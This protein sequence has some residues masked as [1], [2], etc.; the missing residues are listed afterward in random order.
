LRL[1]DSRAINRD[2]LPRIIAADRATNVPI[3]SHSM[4]TVAISINGSPI[5]VRSA[6]NTMSQDL[7][8][9]HMYQVDDGSI[10]SHM[11]G[12]GAVALAI[13]LLKLVKEPGVTP[14]VA[15]RKPMRK[16]T[17]GRGRPIK[18]SSAG[19]TQPGGLRETQ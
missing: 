2:N 8:G 19:R 10:V 18:L 5:I 14:P 16:D 11:R 7:K 4:I 3:M 15:Q 12:D 17:R 1:I 9:R 6:V 13:R